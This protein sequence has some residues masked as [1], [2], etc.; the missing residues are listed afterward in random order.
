MRASHVGEVIADTGREDL[1]ARIVDEAPGWYSPVAHLL[2]PSFFGLFVIVW[3]ASKLTPMQTWEWAVVPLTWLLSNASEW[4]VHKRLLHKR[5]WFAT[6]LYDRHSPEHHM[7]FTHDDMVVRS[8]TEWR[9]VLLPAWAIV[10]LA[11]GVSPV[12][13]GLWRWVS[14]NTGLL[15]LATAMGYVVSY[16]WL[17]LSYHLA[18][19]HPVSKLGIVR[20][21][22]RH[23]ATHHNPELM[24]KWNFNVT[25]PLTDLA[26]GTVYR[27][28]E[29]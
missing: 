18:A 10:L 27:D 7:L 24:Q 21:L 22:G 14:P 12:T 13:A 17:H 28:G 2:F 3:V 8:R 23:H 15:F 6:A 11:I 9:K 20:R 5:R 25:I 26:V 4:R 29:G 19:D 16:E 1:R